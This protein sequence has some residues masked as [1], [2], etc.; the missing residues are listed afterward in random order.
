[1]AIPYTPLLYHS[2]YGV[3][4]SDFK[5]LFEQLVKYDL[6]SCGLVDITFF[7]LHEFVKCAKEYGVKPIIGI[8]APFIKEGRSRSYLIVQ[9]EEGYRNLCKIITRNSF[10]V[11]DI[12]YVK[13]HATGIILLSNS[14]KTLKDIGPLFASK[15]YLLFP[16]HAV[17]D[18]AFPAI[19]VNEIFYV[20][21]DEK[22]LYQLM[23]AIKENQYEHHPG[24]P[25]HLLSKEEFNR[26]FGDYPDAIRN[27]TE[28]S[29]KCSYVLENKG[30]IFPNSDQTLTQI[31]RSKVKDLSPEEKSRL[32]YEYE[33]VMNTGFAPHFSLV[34]HLK[35]FA[36]QRGIGMNVRGSAASSFILY[37]LGLS[38][39][40]PLKHNLPFERFLN[41]QRTEPPDIDVDVEFSERDK[42]IKEIHQKFGSDHVAHIS[43]INRF[44]RR[45]SFRET[46]RAH[47]ISPREI[48]NIDNHLEEKAIRAVH[49]LSEKIIGYPHYFS[50]HP[51]GIVIT[52]ERIFG[53]V[54]LYPSPADQITHLDKDG[55][56]M[57]GLVKIDILG[58]RG[59]P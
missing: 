39:T 34:Y 36:L 25:N 26:L 27:T 18:N 31:I 30:W 52:P 32:D 29:E 15:Y 50:C 1:M 6:K 46:A 47:G 19:T 37:V 57:V 28:L 56:E 54:P 43:V 23:C 58:V 16:Y 21:K 8:S 10:G 20:L 14:I 55:I 22:K 17:V 4:G 2:N 5:T 11:I 48:K 41:P 45:A 53:Y 13:Q 51:S 59:F 49:N 3:G 24:I 35:E 38:I 9:N 42:L 44:K 33:V 7:G 40:N 12:D